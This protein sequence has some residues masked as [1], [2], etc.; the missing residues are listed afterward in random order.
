MA[1]GTNPGNAFFFTSMIFSEP[2]PTAFSRMLPGDTPTDDLIQ[3]NYIMWGMVLP[4]DVLS[5]TENIDPTTLNNLAISTS[6]SYHPVLHRFV[7]TA[8]PAFTI[9]VTFRSAVRPQFWSPSSNATLLGDA[10]HSMPPTGAQGG[11]T[12]LRDAELLSRKLIEAFES[13][14]DELSQE[15][16]LKKAVGEYQTEMLEY[17]F[18]EVEDSTGR[19]N[20]IAETKGVMRWMLLT[21]IPWIRSMLGLGFSVGEVN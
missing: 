15:E 21:V 19:M 5:D 4:P 3:E 1:L 16:K 11:N 17:A 14:G 2:P 20:K 6:K 7:T 9:A 10:I 12:A 18:K 8:D 13:N